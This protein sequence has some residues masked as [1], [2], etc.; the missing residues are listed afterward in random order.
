[1]LRDGLTRMLEAHGLE[2]IAAVDNGDD[3][4]A[5][6]TADPPDLA[7]V[8][9]R[10][11]PRQATGPIDPEALQSLLAGQP[12]RPQRAT[13]RGWPLRHDAI[14]AGRSLLF[15]TPTPL[16]SGPNWRSCSTPKWSHPNIPIR[17]LSRTATQVCAGSGQDRVSRDTPQPVA[18]RA[19]RSA[20]ENVVSHLRDA[21][22][23]MG[24]STL[25]A[26]VTSAT[27]D[28]GRP[29]ARELARRAMT[30]Q[31]AE[32]A[33]DLFVERGYEETTIDDICS[34]AGISRSSFFRYFH[35]KEDVLL[36]EV[37]DV[38][39]SLLTA[40]EARPEHETPWVA[41]RRSLSP[42]IGQYGAESQRVMRSA[43]LVRATPA[44]TTFRQEKLAR[45]AQLL[46]PEVAR[47]M[48]SD[49][50]DPTDPRPA[51]LVAAI[52]ACVDAAVAAWASADGGLPLPR[53]IDS[54]L[55]AIG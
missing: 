54:A 6:V 44:L 21:I 27:R 34:V 1:L 9:I 29:G 31:V 17:C 33:I 8:D 13:G 10:L 35:S 15:Q 49:P 20:R 2:V 48:G 23:Q 25:R 39:E 45:W 52:V 18:A 51:A 26:V 41:L 47:R 37:A 42:L 43:R 28:G 5:A 40:L 24:R 30:A 3:L 53:L 38:G 19:D 50:G 16:P 4:V 36:R 55:D 22:S 14:R 7:I 32:M 11:P 46:I 12:L